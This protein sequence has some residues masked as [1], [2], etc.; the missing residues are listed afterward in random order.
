M[1]CR[2]CAFGADWL[3]TEPGD[4]TIAAEAHNAC[5]QRNAELEPGQ[6]PDCTCQ[7]APSATP[8]PTPRS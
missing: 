7:H 4:R 8:A 1:I 5:R 3:T 6:L 2:E